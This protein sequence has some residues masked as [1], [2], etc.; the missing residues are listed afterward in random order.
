MN[1]N[2]LKAMVEAEALR[3]QSSRDGFSLDA[4]KAYLGQGF[5][6]PAGV[7]P[8]IP[9]A[10]QPLSYQYF[11]NLHGAQF[12]TAVYSCLLGRGPDP[13][14]M[15]H[16]LQSLARG[17]DKA[18]LLGRV[19]FSEE[20]RKR[21]VPVAGLKLKY[22]IAAAK[23]IPLAGSVLAWLL[24][25]ATIHRQQRYAR[26]FEQHVFSRLD[27]MGSYTAQS[28]EQVAMRIDALRAVLEARD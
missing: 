11:A 21:A 22:M 6:P 25:L 4:V 16:N 10:P 23:K 14:G 26:A 28:S 24:A 27:A 1:L 9:P 18:F 5:A 8:A 3:R 2:E 15:E 17:E 13:G 20:G 19:A 7:L 12:V